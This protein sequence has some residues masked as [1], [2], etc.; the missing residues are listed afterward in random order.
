MSSM[1]RSMRRSI[2]KNYCS[3]KYGNTKAFKKEWKRL[4]AET[5]ETA[6]HSSL[7]DKFVTLK[8]VLK[9]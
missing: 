9:K 5:N 2:V 6:K 3:R 1:V 4:S 8:N 7:L